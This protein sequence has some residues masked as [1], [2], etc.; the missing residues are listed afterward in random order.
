M[1]NQENRPATDAPPAPDDHRG[2][3]RKLPKVTPESFL[4]NWRNVFNGKEDPVR[5]VRPMLNAGFAGDVT[6]DHVSVLVQS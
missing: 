1:G 3:K 2:T 6:N 5:K 4:E